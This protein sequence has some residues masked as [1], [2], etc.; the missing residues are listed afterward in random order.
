MLKIGEF[1]ER[2]MDVKFSPHRD[3]LLLV[4]CT[5]SGTIGVWTPKDLLNLANKSARTHF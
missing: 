2:V 4:A 5:W 1:K 3:K